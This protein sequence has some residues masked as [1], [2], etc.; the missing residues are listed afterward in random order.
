MPSLLFP[1]SLLLSL[2][3]VRFPSRLSLFDPVGTLLKQDASLNSGLFTFGETDFSAGF[4]KGSFG[5]SKSLRTASEGHGWHDRRCGRYRVGVLQIQRSMRDGRD[6]S[7]ESS[8]SR[9][10]LDRV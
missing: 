4:A 3:H 7:F 10:E 2:F 5:F 6:V 1:L 8:R 9:V